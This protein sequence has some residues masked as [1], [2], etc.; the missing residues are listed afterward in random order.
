MLCL[1]VCAA[2][3]IGAAYYVVWCGLELVVSVQYRSTV[4]DWG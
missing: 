1:E 4:N 3:F 2:S